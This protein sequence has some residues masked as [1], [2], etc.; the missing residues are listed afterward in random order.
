[1]NL[2][3]KENL[4]LEVRHKLMQTTVR[5]YKI[6]RIRAKISYHAFIAR[7]T[8]F[9]HIMKQITKTNELIHGQSELTIKH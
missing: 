6:L 8:I 3:Q 7:H 1:M 4:E 5:K 9:E 2:K